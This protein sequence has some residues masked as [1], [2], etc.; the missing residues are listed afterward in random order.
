MRHATAHLLLAAAQLSAAFALTL[1]VYLSPNL[2]GEEALWL[3]IACLVVGRPAF[4]L[5]GW[6]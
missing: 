2:Y 6:P 1:L 5:L 4:N 3:A